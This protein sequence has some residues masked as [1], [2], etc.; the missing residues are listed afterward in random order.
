[1]LRASI[2]GNLGGDPEVRYTQKG[3]EI[4]S[5]SVA[6]NQRKRMP[7]SDELKEVTEWFRVRCSG[8][9]ADLA[10]KLTKGQR[11]YVC[12]RLE[13]N[14]FER[15]DGSRGTSY[16]VWADELHGMSPPRDSG[17][18]GSSYKQPRMEDGAPGQSAQPAV[19]DQD[20][21]LPFLRT[22]RKGVVL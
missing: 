15:R 8:W 13:I 17:S 5:V 14:H 1:V 3:E 2:I 6:V 11:V 18:N 20:E 10:Q 7:D 9:R 22:D 16:D 12:G 4:V 21:D 19:G